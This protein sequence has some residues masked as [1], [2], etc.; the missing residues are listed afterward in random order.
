M[1]E[2]RTACHRCGAPYGGEARLYC[3]S[4]GAKQA[5]GVVDLEAYRGNP[6]RFALVRQHRA[7]EAA[8]AWRPRLG[9]AAELGQPL[10]I[11]LLVMVWGGGLAT[12]VWVAKADAQMR[13]M[14]TAV[15]AL[16]SVVGIVP[17]VTAARRLLAPTEQM[18]GVVAEDV[19]R[20]ARGGDPAGVA[21]HRVT[22]RME[23]GATR[24]VLA[25]EVTMGVVALADIGVATVQGPRLVD[26]RRFDVMPAPLGPGEVGAPPACEAC[27]AP[28]TF[29]SRTTCLYCGAALVHPERG[30]HGARFA[31]A[32][33][34]AEAVKQRAYVPQLP[35]TT[36]ASAM[37]I[38]AGVVVYGMWIMRYLWFFLAEE[39]PWG[40]LVLVPAIGF[41]M[42]AVI[43]GR[44]RW[45]PWLAK[46][47]DEVSLVVRRRDDAWAAVNGRPV[48]AHYV[49]IAGPGGGRVE[50]RAEA[51][52]A[53]DARPG[54]I[55]VAHRRGGWLAWWSPLESAGEGG[56]L[57]ADAIGGAGAGG[58]AEHASVD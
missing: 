51:H 37:L 52:V 15:A 55:G 24:D 39:W 28:Y 32:G 57:G 44:R 21:N 47:R 38:A 7:Y 33:A 30:E 11:L 9:V 56:D 1:S 4:C 19:A 50:L 45:T 3:R 54:T 49:T 23:D 42:F 48:V 20:P 22:L 12:V 58:E 29:E 25:T 18:L 34:A 14:F 2:T 40:L 46:R 10:A 36:V 13:W 41:V 5:T 8:R 43:Y 26:F 53:R 27:A 35:S 31:R 6:E 16:M 17:V